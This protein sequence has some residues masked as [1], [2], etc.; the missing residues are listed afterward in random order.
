[1][2]EWQGGRHHRSDTVCGNK[3]HIPLIHQWFKNKKRQSAHCMNYDNL[4]Y[5]VHKIGR[6]KIWFKV[7]FSHKNM[8]CFCSIQILNYLYIHSKIFVK[9]YDLV[10]DERD[11]KTYQKLVDGGQIELS[12]FKT[13]GHG[14]H[15]RVRVYN[16]LIWKVG[17][18]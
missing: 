4:W 6:Y 13:S 8:V 1:M 17:R 18:L 10:Q 14:V 5:N 12:N 3:L 2:N 16:C 11:G 9:A 15:G 7:I